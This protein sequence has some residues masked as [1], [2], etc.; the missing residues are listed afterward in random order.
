M[1]K[2]KIKCAQCQVKEKICRL[3]H[4]QGPDFCPTLHEKELIQKAKKEYKK[5]VTRKFA[6]EASRQEAEGYSH[7][8]TK[9]PEPRPVKTRL[10]EICELAKKMG[11]R[12]IG[13]AFCSGLHTEA[14]Y[15]T[16]ILEAQGFEVISVVCKVGRIPKEFLGLKEEEKIRIGE[17]EAM[18][19]PI[20]QA[21]ILNQQKTDFNILVGLCVGHDSLFLKYAQ[22][23]TTVLVV[24]DRVL[25]HNPCAALYTSHSYYAHL[26]K[27]ES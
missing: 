3:P 4:G 19:S 6:L 16:R 24:K 26:L 10:E 21:M 2:M 18:C 13:V 7:R 12:K 9:P 22:A 23:W 17:F 27:K 5:P 1:E 25:G 20:A 8:E 11:Y 15:L 14:L